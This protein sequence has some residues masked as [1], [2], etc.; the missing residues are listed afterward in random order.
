MEFVMGYLVFI[1]FSG[2]V[3][4]GL[5]KEKAKADAWRIPEKTLLAIAF[6]GGSLGIWLG[7]KFFRHKTRHWYFKYGIPVIFFVELVAMSY[8]ML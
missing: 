5:D 2:F 6:I 7:M 1:N 3:L 4:M 8:V